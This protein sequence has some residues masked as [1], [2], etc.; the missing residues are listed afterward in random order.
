M[1]LALTTALTGA[2]LLTP[3]AAAQAATVKAPSQRVLQAALDA[4]VA[5]GGGQAVAEVRWGGSTHGLASGEAGGRRARAG[6]LFR[7]GSV[8]KVFTATVVLQLVGER[9][10]RLEDTVERW[11]PGVVE[12][13]GQIT[14]KQRTPGPDTGWGCRSARWPAARSMGTAA[15]SPGTAP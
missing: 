12:K 3:L 15:A 9:K 7:I 2:L 11:L 6:D 4:I 13:A 10:L 1:K 14:V 5:E 8:T